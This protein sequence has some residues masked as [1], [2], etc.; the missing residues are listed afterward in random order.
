MP[1]G[2]EQYISKKLAWMN[3]GQNEVTLLEVRKHAVVLLF[4]REHCTAKRLVFVIK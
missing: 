3:V 2:L 4:E 1:T